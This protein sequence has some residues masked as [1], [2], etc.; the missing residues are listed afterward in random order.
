[1]K[2]STTEL[3]ERN[4]INQDQT[5]FFSY[6]NPVFEIMKELLFTNENDEGTTKP[7]KD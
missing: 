4:L 3:I 5:S 6:F 2:T 7:L 1:M